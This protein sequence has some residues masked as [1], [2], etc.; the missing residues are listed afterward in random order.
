MHARSNSG[1]YFI[2]ES[3]HVRGSFGRGL[4]PEFKDTASFDRGFGPD[5]KEICKFGPGLCSKA[6]G[7]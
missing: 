7:N 5:I 1:E 4:G 3:N 6:T 2:K